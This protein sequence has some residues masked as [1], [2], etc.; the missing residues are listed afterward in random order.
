LL[1]SNNRRFL[2]LS[3]AMNLASRF[4]RFSPDLAVDLG[5]A[6]TLV[7]AKRRGVVVNEPS[8]V[9]IDKN[10]GQVEAVGREAREMLGRTPPN[11]V[12][13][14]PMK[15][16]VIADF[17]IAECMLVYF[18]RKAYQYKMLVRP[19]MVISVPS[20]ITQVEERAVVDAAH[21]AKARAVYLV[22]QA[23]MAAV[24]A[25]LPVTEPVGNM[26][27]DIG[28][29]TTNVAVISLGAVVHSRSIR[30]AGN[31]M[32]EAIIQY[33]RSKHGLAVGERTAEAI[34]IEIG[35]AYPLDQP[36]TMEAKGSS[37]IEG[38]PKTIT[39]SDR[40]I[41]ES[42]SEC[43]D[44]IVNAIRVVLERTPPE[45]CADIYDRGILLTGGGAL[46]R[47]LDKRIR[48]ETGLPICI[49]TDPFTSVVFGAGKILCDLKLMGRMVPK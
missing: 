26:V 47:D 22:D 44:A 40:E 43:V 2:V 41:R 3:P 32:D 37:F 19:R 29:G 24:G 31:A 15:D 34:K 16:G 13:I 33:L 36:L 18:I 23:L 10:T 8:M 1:A 14:K 20:E 25:G 6:N 5:T 7:Y 12:V 49:A 45:L 11:L 38:T 17:K 9:A 35:S 30:L 4:L 21:R 42:L 27:V 39:I 46:L 28:G 48:E